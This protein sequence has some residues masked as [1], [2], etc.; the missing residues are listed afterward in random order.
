MAEHMLQGRK[1]RFHG[2]LAGCTKTDLD[3]MP[4]YRR[5]ITCYLASDS[6]KCLNP[7]L[8]V[9]GELSAYSAPT[10]TKVQVP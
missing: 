10:R 3:G 7:G 5:F 8:N 2:H 1:N 4:E 9:N 6:H